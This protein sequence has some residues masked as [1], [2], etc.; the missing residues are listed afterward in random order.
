MRCLPRMMQALALASAIATGA[1]ASST[2]STG[3]TPAKCQVS[4][5]PSSNSVV[6]TGGKGTVSVSTQPECAW[7]ASSQANWISEL[8]P[9]S[10]Q[11]N[12]QVAFQVPANPLPVARQGEIEINGNRVAVS[13]EAAPCGFDITPR[14]L[15]IPNTAGTRTVTVTAAAGCTW[16]AS[17]NAAWITVTT[18]ATG[19]GN[20]SMGFSVTANAGAER[21]GHSDDCRP[22]VYRHAGFSGLHVHDH[23]DQ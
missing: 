11:G 20:G 13:Q 16:S 1:C 5:D 3:P 22:D 21:I 6:A 15:A 9:T 18:G 23:T 2:T 10:G 7:T 19:T 8:A 4:L 14:S 12:G 17:S